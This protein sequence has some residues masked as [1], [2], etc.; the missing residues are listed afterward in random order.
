[1]KEVL[2]RLAE[3]IFGW[4]AAW[5]RRKYKPKVVAIVG[6]VGK[7]SCK[8]A[9]LKV[10]ESSFRV[11]HSPENSTPFLGAS[12][13]LLDAE[14]LHSPFGWL[15]TGLKGL[16]PIIQKKPYLEIVLVEIRAQRPGDITRISEWLRP[17]VV[18]LTALAP[19]PT[20]VEFFSRPE[21]IFEENARLV[22]RLSR[23][24]WVI[25]NSDDEEVTKIKERTHAKVISFGLAEGSEIH[26]YKYELIFRKENEKSILEGI[27]FQV[28]YKNQEAPVKIFNTLGR[29]HMYA[30]LTAIS[31]GTIFNI[32][33]EQSAEF[34]SRYNPPPG[35]LKVLSGIKDT[36]IIDD[37]YNAS[38]PALRKALEELKEVSAKRKI[39]VLGD[40]LELGKYTIT[41]H[42]EIGERIAGLMDILITVGPRAKFFAEGA[43]RAGFKKR[44]I[45][46][47][48]DSD[49]A[50]E[51][52]AELIK[53]GDLI[54]VSGARAL[55]MENVVEKIMA[56]PE[57]KAEL[58]YREEPI[59]S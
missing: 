38:P 21:E 57:R 4:E 27:R 48:S 45:S 6:S 26:A 44:S 19:T 36:L 58:L 46:S 11:S 53:P 14:S 28:R 10:L 9:C 50:A 35:R 5:I 23:E 30:G 24:N 12:L 59:E 37:S 13:A 41:A 49:E 55:R 32:P 51:K 42:R 31:L 20:H 43:A 22:E 18:I 3:K 40:M 29:Q 56:E 52:L 54:L 34:L 15:R 33:L 25:L 2:R 39:A 8:E 17:E 7:T 1:M 47:F 16:A